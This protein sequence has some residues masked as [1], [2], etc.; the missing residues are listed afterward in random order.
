MAEQGP[1][2]VYASKAWEI[3]LHRRELRSRGVSVPIGSRAFE[4][5]EVLVQ[6]GG[7]LVNKYHLIDRVWPGAVV[8][9]N[10]LHFHISAIRKAFGADRTLLNTVSGRGYRLLGDWAVQQP[11]KPQHRVDA[12]E[13][14]PKHPYRT[15]V[16]VA[17]SALIGRGAPTQ[18]LMTVLS[19]YRVVTLTGPPGIG[20]SVGAGGRA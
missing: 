6:S 13:H 4:L 12:S 2:A 20:K 3:D 11:G 19:A 1:R 16:P 8:E 7:E 17:A 9:E 14:K 10:T 5:L 18:H 15:N